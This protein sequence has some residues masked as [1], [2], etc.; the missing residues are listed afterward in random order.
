MKYSVKQLARAY[1]EYLSNQGFDVRVKVSQPYD[2]ATYNEY[3]YKKLIEQYERLYQHTDAL[4][5]TE[6]FLKGE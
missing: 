1:C 6:K 2:L 5:L 3:E 4:A